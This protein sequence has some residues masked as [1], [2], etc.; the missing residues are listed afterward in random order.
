MPSLP[1]I[2]L[3]ILDLLIQREKEE[4]LE[5][6]S[7]PFLQIPMPDRPQ[8]PKIE[9]IEEIEEGFIVIDL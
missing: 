7:R 1:L 3:N 9:E 5:T 4:A 8:R 6:D 2:D